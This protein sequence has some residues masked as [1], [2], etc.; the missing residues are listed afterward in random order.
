MVKY[1]YL[2]KDELSHF[3]EEFKQFLIVNHIYHEDW[4]KINKEHPQKALDLVGLFSNQILQRV[5][6]KIKYLE[7]R[8]K[9]Y[10]D[11]FFFDKNEVFLIK[12]ESKIENK[13]NF[14]NAN[15]IHSA[16]TSNF[17]EVNLYKSSK[18]YKATREIEIH[19]LLE[20]G[21]I[22]S[23]KDFWDSLTRLTAN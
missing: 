4:L 16:L 13:F 11:V 23:S 12:V 10:C 22:L 2:E 17:S 20:K 7:F 15:E 8:S 5:Y 1:R 6:E 14:N 18:K 9:N 19:L 21:A 3:E